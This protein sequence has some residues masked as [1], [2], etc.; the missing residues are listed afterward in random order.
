[1]LRVNAIGIMLLLML[2]IGL[3]A[4]PGGLDKSGGH[5]NRKTNEY[6]KHRT[7]KNQDAQPANVAPNRSTPF[8]YSSSI[9]SPRPTQRT[10]PSQ[11]Y[12]G[13][14]ETTEQIRD[15]D[16]IRDAMVKIADF[17][18]R[19]EVW[20]GI[21]IT[22]DGVFSTLDIRIAGIDAP[23]MS[24]RGADRTE[25]SKDRE[26]QLARQARTMLR[27][28]IMSRGGGR[29]TVTQPAHGKFAGRMLATVW[30][31]GT[32]VGE[33]L[34]NSDLAKPYSGRGPRPSWD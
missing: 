13:Y 33:A 17:S 12:T 9:Q 3:F 23:E 19:G 28:L 14:V 32:N 29:F 1:M 11:R 21:V 4:H 30:I 2:P 31:G 10:A 26:R 25:E 27:D 34:I 18:D 16:T 22:D 6:H 24:P 20:P 8:S 7:V 15:G 5:M